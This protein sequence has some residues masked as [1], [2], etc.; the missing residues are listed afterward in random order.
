MNP[1]FT[2]PNIIKETAN[3]TTYCPIQ[4]ELFSVRRCVEVVGEITRDS[5]YSLIL[6][7]RYLCHAD[8]EKEITMYIS[9]AALLYPDILR[10]FAGKHGDFYILPSS[11]YEVLLLP[12]KPEPADPAYLC[13]MVR[14][15][16][17][18]QVSPDEVLSDN[19]YLYHADTGE[20]DVLE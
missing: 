15:V 17:E 8:Q 10:G 11:I 7:L 5:V 4:D 12:A 6:Q 13:G 9:A 1:Y 18:E 20:I 19:A 14:A 16:N 3:G 2:T